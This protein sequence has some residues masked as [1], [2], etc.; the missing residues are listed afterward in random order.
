MLSAYQ[1][2]STDCPVRQN[3]TGPATVIGRGSGW[4]ERTALEW[5][6]LPAGVMV[7]EG[8][9]CELMRS[10][11]L[12]GHTGDG[13]TARMTLAAIKDSEAG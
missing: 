4:W 12:N 2:Q 3:V 1:A 10:E 5:R 8:P 11:G 9:V 6:R 7:P 13:D